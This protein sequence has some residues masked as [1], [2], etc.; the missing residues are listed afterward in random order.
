MAGQDH[1]PT[2]PGLS[3]CFEINAQLDIGEQIQA[4]IRGIAANR[5]KPMSP[6]QLTAL[7]SSAA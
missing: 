1:P 2:P 3:E 7:T 6:R 5:T 4:T